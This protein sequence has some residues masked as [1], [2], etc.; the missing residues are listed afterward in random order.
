M[1]K[2]GFFSAIFIVIGL[3]IGLSPAVQRTQQPIAVCLVLDTS[4]TVHW[5]QLRVAVE[6]VYKSCAAGDTVLVFGVRGKN[7]QL[8]FSTVKQAADYEFADLRSIVENIKPDWFARADI[9]SAVKGPV[10]QKLLQHAG[11]KGQAVIVI[12]TEGDLSHKQANDLIEFAYSVTRAHQWHVFLT[13]TTNK[14]NKKLLSAANEGRLFWCDLDKV[15]NST[16]IEQWMRRIRPVTTGSAEKPAMPP[17]TTAAEQKADAAKRNFPVE[18]KA[19]PP[20][21]VMAMWLRSLKTYS[22]DSNS[23]V[24]HRSAE[25]LRPVQKALRK[26]LVDPNILRPEQGGKGKPDKVAAIAGASKTAEVASEASDGKQFSSGTEQPLQ[27]P[28]SG[29]SEK[30]SPASK[31]ITQDFS[32]GHTIEKDKTPEPFLTVPKSQEPAEP[33]VMQ[34]APLNEVKSATVASDGGIVKSKVPALLGPLRKWTPEVP[35]VLEE[36]ATPAASQKVTDTEKPPVA[37]LLPASEASREKSVQFPSAVRGKEAL[38]SKMGIESSAGHK[39]PVVKE[40]LLSHLLIVG[41]ISIPS[42]IAFV[43]IC[44]WLAAARW[45]K[46]AEQP[47]EVIQSQE[48]DQ[49][50]ILMVRVNGVLQRIGDLRCL[51]SFHLGS[52]PEN[53]VRIAEK[54]ISSRHARVSRKGGKLF[55]RNMSKNPIIVNGQEVQPRK[56]HQLILPSVVTVAEGVSIDFFLEE[57]PKENQKSEGKQNVT[58][59]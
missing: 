32:L 35:K 8:I 1:K 24:D 11:P 5:P 17:T 45:Q 22:E 37:R 49:P 15:V 10:Y 48:Q 26:E 31:S 42:L 30:P 19:P 28:A 55:I 12:I 23:T 51:K 14:T 40:R 59:S 41:G 52:A 2:R 18:S 7:T 38:S 6:N 39:T 36:V 25:A 46:A 58:S 20:A 50:Q 33:N 54:V 21:T 47:L 4:P 53:T 27:V 3:L 43:V 29:T 9:A 44:G 13:G 16:A 34:V 56:R 57:R